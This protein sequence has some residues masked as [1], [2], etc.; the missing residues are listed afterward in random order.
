MQLMER[1]QAFPYTV[2]T[3]ALTKGLLFASFLS[4][5]LRRWAMN[6]MKKSGLLNVYTPEKVFLELEK[7]KLIEYTKRKVIPTELS[8][9]QREILAAMD[10]Q[11]EY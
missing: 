3:Q 6:H 7:I 9:K 2:H 4:L 11:I 1:K 10:L 5:L 8:M